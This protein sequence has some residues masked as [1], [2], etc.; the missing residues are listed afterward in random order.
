MTSPFCSI[1]KW[2]WFTI[3]VSIFQTPLIH[4][5]CCE[6]ILTVSWT[7]CFSEPGLVNKPVY[8]YYFIFRT[9]LHS[10]ERFLSWSIQWGLDLLGWCCTPAGPND[11]GFFQVS[12]CCVLNFSWRKTF[13]RCICSLFVCIHLILLVIYGEFCQLMITYNMLS[14]ECSSKIHSSSICRWFQDLWLLILSVSFYVYAHQCQTVTYSY[15]TLLHNT[16]FGWMRIRVY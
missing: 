3:V 9:L 8:C 1:I 4:K 16:H 5:S 10:E 12:F 14:S 7:S 11:P 13:L 15:L 2:L 6:T